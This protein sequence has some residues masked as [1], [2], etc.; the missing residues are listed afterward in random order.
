MDQ[1]QLTKFEKKIFLNKKIR[2]KFNIIILKY[3]YIYMYIT[4][5]GLLIKYILLKSKVYFHY[6]MYKNFYYRCLKV[7]FLYKLF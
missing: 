2:K 6:I 1:E 7:V 5:C 3:I 4:K